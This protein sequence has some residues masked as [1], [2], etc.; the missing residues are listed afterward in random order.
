MFFGVIFLGAGAALGEVCHFGYLKSF[1]SEFIG[2]FI[3][4]TGF[5]GLFASLLYLYLHSEGVPDW[6]IFISL[7]PLAITY[8][9]NFLL[10]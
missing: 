5:S 6:I 7:I 2:P 1:P 10:I 3:S 8:I 4:G 9:A